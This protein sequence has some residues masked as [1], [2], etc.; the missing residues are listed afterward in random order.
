MYFNNIKNHTFETSMASI[1][2]L[3]FYTIRIA[4]LSPQP[5]PLPLAQYSKDSP[6]STRPFTSSPHTVRIMPSQ[7]DPLPLAQYS[8]NLPLPTGPFTSSSI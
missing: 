3:Y 2:T 6:P 7:P 4:P 8:K 1:W 5:D